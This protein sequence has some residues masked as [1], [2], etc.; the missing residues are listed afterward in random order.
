MYDHMY[1][2][3][4]NPGTLHMLDKFSDTKL[5]PHPAYENFLIMY[6]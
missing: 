5:N 1:Y 3:T 6:L 2:L 4:L